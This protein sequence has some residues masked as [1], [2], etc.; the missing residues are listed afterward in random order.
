[1]IIQIYNYVSFAVPDI[2]R[3]HTLGYTLCALFSL[4]VSPNTFNLNP[5]NVRS[6]GAAMP[7][8]C[9][10]L[11]FR[12]FKIPAVPHFLPPHPTNTH[13]PHLLYIRD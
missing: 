7:E 11:L 9:L 2:P 5:G 3:V 10:L 8:L 4:S 6:T 12:R 13:T 1:M